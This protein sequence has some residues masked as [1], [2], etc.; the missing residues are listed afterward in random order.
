VP[1]LTWTVTSTLLPPRVGG[2]FV[3]RRGDETQAPVVLLMVN[4]AASAPPT[5]L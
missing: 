3:V 1:S 4:L 2:R 5:M